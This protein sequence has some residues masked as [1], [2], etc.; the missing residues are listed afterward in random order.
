MALSPSSRLLKSGYAPREISDAAQEATRIRKER[1]ETLRELRSKLRSMVIRPKR[2]NDHNQTTSRPA[3]GGVFRQRK[4]TTISPNTADAKSE[5]QRPETLAT[6]PSPIVTSPIK[7]PHQRRRWANRQHKQPLISLRR[8]QTISQFSPSS[9]G[10]GTDVRSDCF[11]CNGSGSPHIPLS[12]SIGKFAHFPSSPCDR[13]TK[14]RCVP[15]RQ[16][17]ADGILKMNNPTTASPQVLLQDRHH[18]IQ[19]RSCCF[20]VPTMSPKR[21]GALASPK[22]PLRALSPRQL[23]FDEN[24]APCDGKNGSHPERPRC[25][26]PGLSPKRKR[27]VPPLRRLIP[28]DEN[29]D[30]D[31]PM[32]MLASPKR[33]RTPTKVD[34]RPLVMP[35]RKMSP[36][37]SPLAASRMY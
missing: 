28:F 12:P 16:Q 18:G 27:A 17:Q 21:N 13:L 37:R 25:P 3:F 30:H 29:S 10:I 34:P 9:M 35:E 4:K 20:P 19:Q 23:G 8:R 26:I 31:C 5:A 15:T 11:E 33:L 2:S 6:C 14:G 1:S 22:V 24:I 32:P 7:S 36:P